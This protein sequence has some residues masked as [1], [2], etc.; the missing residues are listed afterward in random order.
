MAATPESVE[1]AIAALSNEGAKRGTGLSRDLD[2]AT[3]LHEL[4][5]WTGPSNDAS[6]LYSSQW[7]SLLDDVLD[8]L[9]AVGPELSA[10]LGADDVREELGGCRRA[11]KSGPRTDRALLRR[12]ALA[13]QDL[14]ARASTPAG[15]GAAFADLVRASDHERAGVLARLLIGLAEHAGHDPANFASGV[16]AA[17][18]GGV[19]GAQSPAELDDAKAVVMEPPERSDLVV[20]VRFLNASLPGSVSLGAQVTLYGDDWLRSILEDPAL[21]AD[22][23]P[24]IGFEA[25]RSQLQHLLGELTTTPAEMLAGASRD[26]RL[27]AARISVPSA[28]VT[29]SR[30]IA[31]VTAEAIA[32]IGSI[33]GLS[34]RLWAFDEGACLVVDDDDFVFSQVG[35]PPFTQLDAKTWA[36]L[37]RSLQADAIF[38][39]L[40]DKI[41]KHLPVTDE[42]IKKATTLSAWLRSAADSRPGPRVLLYGR[43]VEQVAKWAGFDDERK[44]IDEVLGPGWVLHQVRNQLLSAAFDA[45]NALRRTGEADLVKTFEQIPEAGDDFRV[46]LREYLRQLDDICTA[47]ERGEWVEDRALVRSKNI[48]LQTATSSAAIGWLDTELERFRKLEKRRRRTRNSLAHGGPAVEQTIATVDRFAESLA[49]I[50]LGDCIDGQLQGADV[51][52]H[53]LRLS[54]ERTGVWRRLRRRH[55]FEEALFM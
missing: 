43:V 14:A 5:S 6:A 49:L 55:P 8:S 37:H 11:F 12:T 17:L 45:M 13:A 40:S 15:L 47:L 1:R 3:V 33:Y 39:G 16:L 7:V 27:V 42:S 54:Q 44:F 32:G 21:V 9:V 26:K 20:W 24:E 2:L 41:G 52:D 53:F 4:S 10:H 23:A 29:E 22:I 50:A 25:V 46:D 38:T 51:T 30:M 34:A 48:R 18:R 19:H 35:R 28:T 36:E 31:S